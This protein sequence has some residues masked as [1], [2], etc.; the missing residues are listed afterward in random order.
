VTDKPE[1]IVNP[2]ELLRA[3]IAELALLRAALR[4]AEEVAEAC[5]RQGCRTWAERWD[6]PILYD[7]GG[8]STYADG[9]RW[10]ARRGRVEIVR[11]AGRVVIAREIK[12]EMT[13]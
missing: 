1:V 12:K 13:L 6:G 4:E 7:S 9:L 11:D 2:T 10:M 3:A 8:L 5:L